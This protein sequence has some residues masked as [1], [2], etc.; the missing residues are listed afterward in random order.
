[1]SLLLSVCLTETCLR[2]DSLT[3]REERKKKAKEREWEELEVMRCFNSVE[4]ESARKRN[5]EK[6]RIEGSNELLRE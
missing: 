5:R 4:R 2:A 3:A 1:M 6:L